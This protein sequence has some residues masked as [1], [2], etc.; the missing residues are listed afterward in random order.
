MSSIE[1]VSTTPGAMWPPAIK[2]RSVAAA[3]SSISL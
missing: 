3:C 2:L 1:R